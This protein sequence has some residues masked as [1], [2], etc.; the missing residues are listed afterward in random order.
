MTTEQFRPYSQ[1]ELE[2]LE[3]D[4]YAR[5][6]LGNVI[7]VH[8][9]CLHEYKVKKGGRKEQ[10]ILAAAIDSRVLDDQTC[11]V[12]F[13]LRT[14]VDEESHPT[15]PSTDELLTRDKLLRLDSFYRWLYKHDF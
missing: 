5:H 2:D 12:C 14:N 1:S 9:P 7:A 4:I 8:V 15:L 10:Q 3:K 11:S 6:R 13:K